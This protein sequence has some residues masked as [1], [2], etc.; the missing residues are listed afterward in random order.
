MQCPYCKEE[1][2]DGA[3]V[4]RYCGKRQPQPKRARRGRIIWTVLVIVSLLL[5]VGV[6]CGIQNNAE[7]D[8]L[9][10]QIVFCSHGTMTEDQVRTM[11]QQ[12]ADKANMTRNEALRTMRA[13]T[14]GS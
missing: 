10:R 1:I 8:A 4:C 2:K 6:A 14:C 9:V 12:S 3:T 11:G 13:L 5:V 7:E